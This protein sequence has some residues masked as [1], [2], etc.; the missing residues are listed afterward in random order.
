MEPFIV[1]FSKS[2]SS[3]SKEIPVMLYDVTT[4]MMV[5]LNTKGRQPAIDAPSIGMA[6][7]TLI[8]EAQTDP[9]R[10]EQVDR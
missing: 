9:T 2:P 8:T 4:E 5:I 3:L 1:K 7:G 6:T 10:D